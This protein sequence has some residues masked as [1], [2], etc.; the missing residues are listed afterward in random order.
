[1]FKDESERLYKEAVINYKNKSFDRSLAL[2]EKIIA[3]DSKYSEAYANISLIKKIKNNY[4]ASFYYLKKAIDIKPQNAIY[5]FD[6]GNLLIE[7]KDFN[8][9]ISS[10]LRAIKL[11]FTSVTIYHNLAMAYEKIGDE[12]KA[13]IT[14]KSA[15]KI[16]GTFANTYNI[17]GAILFRQKKYQE[18]ADMFSMALTVDPKIYGAH[19]NKGACLNKLK[20][21]DEAITELILAIKYDPENSSAYTNIGNV[22]YKK[23]NYQQ[24]IKMHQQSIKLNANVANSHSNLANSFKKLGYNNQAIISYKRAIQLKPDYVNAHFDLA[25]TYLMIEDFINGWLEYEWRSAKEEMRGH[26]LHY[27]KILSFP[28]FTGKE[29]I[30]NKKILIYSEQGFGDSLQFIRYVSTLEEKHKCKI[31]IST[32]KEL[33]TLFKKNYDLYEVICRKEDEVPN[34]DYQVSLLSF[35]YVLNM[36]K[37][38]EIPLIQ[39]YLFSHGESNILI[40]K[41]EKIIYVGINWSASI[42]GETFQDKVFDLKYFEPLFLN[43]KIKVYSLQ[44]G[45]QSKDIKKYGFENNIVDLSAELDSFDKT[46]SLI[47]QLDI[48]ISSDTSVAHLSGA[49]NKEVWI[50]LQKVPD[51][52]WGIKSE[53]SMW[54][55][56]A[57]LFRQKH[58]GQW[59]SVF[60]SI[61]TEMNKKYNINLNK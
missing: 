11:N 26:K 48:V 52:R 46:A 59:D 28:L 55:K 21:Y 5:H 49:L 45:P 32:Q 15:I 27:E 18:S 31:I 6:M 51:W 60:Q 47:N 36:K 7:S 50:A 4:E 12:K 44:V 8:K 38:D 40:K 16:D 57:R 61:F 53:Y 25:T 23:Y 14:L 34:F 33:V 17:I 41:E 3:I 35:P 10:Y 37:K 29:N 43:K 42:D 24:A 19:S 22:Y 20:K 56:S 30:V 2:F 1:M 13:V 58:N 39:P 9:A 54:Y